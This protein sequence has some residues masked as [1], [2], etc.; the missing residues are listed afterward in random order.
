MADDK[1]QD[2]LVNL[3]VRICSGE[4]I[5]MTEIFEKTLGFPMSNNSLL[6][7][8]CVFTKDGIRHVDTGILI[9]FDKPIDS[10]DLEKLVQNDIL[11]EASETEYKK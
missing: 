6:F 4:E 7:K 8:N 1:T 2:T 10:D 3:M 9:P 5:P 11:N